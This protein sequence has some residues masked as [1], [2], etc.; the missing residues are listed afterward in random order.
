MTRNWKREGGGG[1]RQGWVV[2]VGRRRKEPTSAISQV[3]V[4]TDR[5]RGL[6]GGGR[7]YRTTETLFLVLQSLSLPG[8]ASRLFGKG[9]G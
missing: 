9:L 7:P 8:L 1:R 4:R 5:R 3:E 2:G 6:R